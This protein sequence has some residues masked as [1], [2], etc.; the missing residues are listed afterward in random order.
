MV[1]MGIYA[2]SDFG[3]LAAG[4]A[5]VSAI[6]AALAATTATT[7]AMG[8]SLTPPGG[9]GSSVRAVAQQIA[10]V[11]HFAAMFT[12]GLEQLQERVGTTSVFGATAEA[13]EASNAMSVAF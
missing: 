6:N 5:A 1:G 10:A 2:V 9:D 11:N 8:S 7:E 3:E 12:M 4:N 13:V